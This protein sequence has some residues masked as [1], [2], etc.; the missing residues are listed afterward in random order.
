MTA[1]EELTGWKAA[2][3][4]GD[5]L[6][7]AFLLF[8]QRTRRAA[9]S[10]VVHALRTG[11]AASSVG[12]KVLVTYILKPIDERE[13]RVGIEVAIYRHRTE[14]RMRQMER[15]MT[16]TLNSIGDGVIATD[17]LGKVVLMNPYAEQLT[18]W[19]MSDARGRS[20]DGV[21]CLTHDQTGE[22]VP[23]PADQAMREG[24]VVHIDRFTMLQPRDG[25]AFYIDDSAAPIALNRSCK[26]QIRP[27]KLRNVFPLRQFPWSDPGLNPGL[28][29]KTPQAIPR[30]DQSAA[31]VPLS[32][33][34]T[35]RPAEPVA[36]RR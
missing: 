35:E 34:S 7:R 12:D 10:E 18:G 9:Q 36:R 28:K 8:D 24:I 32:E 19:K 15:W 23:N 29:G 5:E 21:F 30:P 25:V 13:L 11:Q 1:A 22:A 6:E 14:T 20:L 4:V 16:T 17:K 33:Q 3:V 26:T 31:N 2:E 27:P